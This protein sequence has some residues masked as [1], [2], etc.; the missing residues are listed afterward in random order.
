MIPIDEHHGAGWLI[1]EYKTLEG[2]RLLPKSNE[3]DM[4]RSFPVRWS[5]VEDDAPDMRAVNL[6][7]ESVNDNEN[8]QKFLADNGSYWFTKFGGYPFDLHSQLSCENFVFQIRSEQ[9]PKWMCDNNGIIYFYKMNNEWGFK[10]QL[11]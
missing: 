10:C 5:L 4:V 2:L 1:R 8:V 9:K 7:S 11:Y 6:F 3:P